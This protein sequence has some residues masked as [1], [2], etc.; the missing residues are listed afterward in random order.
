MQ[1]MLF[2]AVKGEWVTECTVVTETQELAY[3]VA[4]GWIS[5]FTYL[6]Q[7]CLSDRYTRQQREETFK[8]K[9][10]LSPS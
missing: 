6:T 4:P 8:G 7:H 3:R 2:G 10:A 1:A 5:D 9:P